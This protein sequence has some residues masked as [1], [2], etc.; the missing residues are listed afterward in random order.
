MKHGSAVAAAAAAAAA[1]CMMTMLKM[2]IKG[3]SEIIAF[4]NCVYRAG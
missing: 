2:L 3:T 4:H 1:D